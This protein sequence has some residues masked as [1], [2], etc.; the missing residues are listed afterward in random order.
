MI[1]LQIVRGWFPLH[2]I[3]C[4]NEREVTSAFSKNRSAMRTCVAYVS[5]FNL[6]LESCSFSFL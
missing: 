2:F 5:I 1:A 3:E 6:E 4:K